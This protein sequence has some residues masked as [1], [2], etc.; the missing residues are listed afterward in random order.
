MENI[1]IQCI[2]DIKDEDELLLNKMI[3]F[4]DNHQNLNEYEK[5]KVIAL[6][7]KFINS[8][9]LSG[10]ESVILA[11]YFNS[12]KNQYINKKLN[13][14]SRISQR[15]LLIDNAMNKE[16]SYGF[17]Y[18]IHWCK[19]KKHDE[20]LLTA[21]NMLNHHAIIYLYKRDIEINDGMYCN[22]IF[23]YFN[24]D[25]KC[26]FTIHDNIDDKYGDLVCIKES[27]HENLNLNDT[28]INEQV[29]NKKNERKNV[30]MR[31]LA[32]AGYNKALFYMA[33]KYTREN[34]QTQYMELMC[35][36]VNQNNLW[37]IME[38]TDKTRFQIQPNI[39][40]NCF[41][42]I[43]NNNTKLHIADINDYTKMNEHSIFACQFVQWINAKLKKQQDEIE[44]LQ[45]MLIYAPEGKGAMQCEENFYNTVKKL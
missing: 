43:L 8:V 31:K 42:K 22:L 30:I 18:K 36:A 27:I 19:Q 16:C 44:E 45:N 12:Y 40:E 28:L 11:S 41:N 15:S 9:E 26:P 29:L 1:N 24:G 25:Q 14:T 33:E 32:M 37:A 17:Y 23:I 34:K 13:N 10:I 7:E 20:Y 39:I 38:L 35:N 3:E 2:S 4:D 21:L 5:N 6:Y